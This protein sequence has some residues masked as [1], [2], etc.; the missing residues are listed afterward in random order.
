MKVSSHGGFEAL[1]GTA[2][3][4]VLVLPI[5]QMRTDGF[6]VYLVGFILA[7]YLLA[8]YMALSIHALTYQDGLFRGK[9]LLGRTVEFR[10]RDVSEIK[11]EN[12][13]RPPRAKI[14]L[15]DGSSILIKKPMWMRA[16][17]KAGF[18]DEILKRIGEIKER[19]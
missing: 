11:S 3:T 15:K 10:M 5:L 7:V 14:L 4:L 6:V 12:F 2:V 9:S 1:L 8:L 17:T 16:I 18:E 19:S 13:S